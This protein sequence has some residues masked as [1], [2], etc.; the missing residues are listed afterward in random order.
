MEV[1]AE[2]QRQALEQERQRL[3]DM[4]VAYAAQQDAKALLQA[5]LHSLATEGDADEALVREAEQKL[6]RAMEA[7]NSLTDS[8]RQATAENQ[9]LGKELR[10]L[11]AHG[12]QLEADVELRSTDIATH[13]VRV[14]E[15]K[16][17]LEAEI[18]RQEE[19]IVSCGRRAT[20]MQE[21]TVAAK[22]RLI[23]V[24]VA[25]HKS[26]L[27]LEEVVAQVTAQEALVEGL[28][29]SAAE[30]RAKR[31]EMEAELARM[32]ELRATGRAALDLAHAGHAARMGAY[33]KDIAD[34]QRQ[35]AEKQEH[36]RLLQQ[37]MV[38]ASHERNAAS[39]AHERLLSSLGDEARAAEE[40]KL[41]VERRQADWIAAS[42]AEHA[43]LHA[44]IQAAN[45]RLVAAREK[46]TTLEAARVAAEKKRK[47]E[48]AAL[49]DTDTLL[50]KAR[51]NNAAQRYVFPPPAIL[52]V[53]HRFCVLLAY[54]SYV[55]AC[56]WISRAVVSS[57][58]SQVSTAASLQAN[59]VHDQQT[60]HHLLE[61]TLRTNA[62]LAQR[63]YEYTAETEARAVAHSVGMQTPA[64]R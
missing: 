4:D 12:A 62:A 63:K 15:R 10:L 22:Q 58:S 34:L 24:G 41:N 13:D 8:V 31:Q 3:A 57:L 16:T 21:D 5:E 30:K 46:R 33:E 14:A 1:R 45:A 27:H 47:Q 51:R 61:Y 39:S 55:S 60:L 11:S 26:E 28:V 37:R 29:T 59:Q 54:N 2:Q 48:R 32:T 19:S 43:D 64:M 17:N 25:M 49:L 6:A 20:Q 56:A 18:A 7:A 36:T 44:Q 35:V 38:S 52:Y 53:L 40:A 50:E 9:R 23:D 42:Q